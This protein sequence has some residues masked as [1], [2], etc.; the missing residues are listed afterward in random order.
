[1]KIYVAHFLSAMTEL[2]RSPGYWVPTILFPVMFYMFFGVAVAG[3][4]ANPALVMASFA[5]YGVVGVAFYQFGVGIAQDREMHWEKF[6][7]TLPGS[8]P[9]RIA[10]RLI[11]AAIFA[12][13]AAGIVLF[14]AH[15]FSA[16]GIS[17]RQLVLFGLVCFAASTPFALMGIALGYWTN[18]KTA[19]PISNMVFLPLAFLGGLWIPPSAMP[20]S[21]AAISQYTPTRHM[22]EL[23]WATM[24]DRSL[25]GESMGFLAGY[26]VIFAGL[27]YIGYRRDEGRRYA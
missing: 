11:T 4:G 23:A 26:A 18:A 5:V 24:L 2:M 8:A 19:V 20:S 16:P 14:A 13:L 15:F 9:A 25:P 7:R 10:A 22:A 12:S 3:R 17:G 21:I 27:A 1:M 6:V